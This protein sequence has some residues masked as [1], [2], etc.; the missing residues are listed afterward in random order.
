[1]PTQ[2]NSM[3][4][5]CKNQ[6]KKTAEVNV[7]VS[8]CLAPSCHISKCCQPDNVITAMTAAAS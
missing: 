7:Q 4:D 3:M 6:I 1:M 8:G 2:F 5:A